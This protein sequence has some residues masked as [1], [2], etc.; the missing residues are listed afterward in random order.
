MQRS[1][2]GMKDN[3]YYSLLDNL[4][5]KKNKKKQNFNT[6]LSKQ[7]IGNWTE[8]G[9]MDLALKMV[10]FFFYLFSPSMK[11]NEMLKSFLSYFFCLLLYC[12]FSYIYFR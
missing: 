5:R 4:I 7:K 1:G 12:L 10:F 11:E 2:G 9:L 8:G 3:F 6:I